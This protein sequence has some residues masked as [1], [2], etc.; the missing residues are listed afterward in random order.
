MNE[1]LVTRGRELND[2]NSFLDAVLSS[3]DAAVVVVDPDFEVQ[4]WNH[5]ARE[6]WGLTTDEAVGQHFL[7]LDIGLPVDQ[8]RNPI[9]TV[10]ASDGAGDGAGPLRLDAVNRRGRKLQCMV[11]LTPLEG[12]A[13]DRHGVI[14]MMQP[15]EAVEPT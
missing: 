12:A 6:L 13:G 7:N 10:L 5:G 11:T 3:L 14:V 4:A 9:R 2:V 15:A 1:E 8:L